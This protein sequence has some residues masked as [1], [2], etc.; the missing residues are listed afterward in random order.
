MRVA[1]FLPWLAASAAC[2][3]SPASHTNVGPRAATTQA[4][5]TPAAP[6]VAPD[7]SAMAAVRCTR[8]PSFPQSWDLPEASSAAEVE[9]V[10]GVRELLAVSDSGHDGE[11]LLWGIPS[12]PLRKL[13]LS[14]DAAAS[15]D[16]E[17]SAWRAGHLYTLTSSG[18][19]RRFSPDG[20]GGLRRDQDAYAIGSQPDVC[21][22]LTA[23][24]CG[25]NYE[26]LC[27]RAASSPGHCAG[28]AASKSA[29]TLRCLVF[30]GEQL[31]LDGSRSPLPLGLAKRALSDCAFGAEGGPA[32]DRLLITT[33]VYGG[34]ATYLVNEADGTLRALDVPGTLTNEAV[35]VDKDGALYQF[36]D[37]N[38]DVSAALRMTCTGWG[39]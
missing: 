39:S 16:I 7:A 22:K 5:A 6:Q 37:D 29:G 14:L 17:G 34:S 24:N 2:D 1:L 11:A 32:Q 28:Y 23:G 30:A 15:D 21:A 3:R 27:L 33:N 12:G 18:A 31:A 9:L 19:V 38:G 10:R 36:M 35:A 4:E 8:D 26:G 13:K 20:K 25:P